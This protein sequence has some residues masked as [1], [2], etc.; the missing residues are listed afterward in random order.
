MT[1]KERRHHHATKGGI[2]NQQNGKLAIKRGKAKRTPE[3]KQKTIN[4]KYN[5]AGV[6]KNK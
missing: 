3:T 5:G 2:E 4:Y 1:T 6:E